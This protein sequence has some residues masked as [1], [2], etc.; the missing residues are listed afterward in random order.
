MIIMKQFAKFPI[1]FLATSLILGC[2]IPTIYLGVPYNFDGHYRSQSPV[3]DNDNF[4]YMRVANGG[5]TVYFGGDNLDNIQGLDYISI[6]AVNIE[7]FEENSYSFETENL[8]GKITF[9]ENTDVN[10]SLSKNIV[11]TFHIENSVL[12]KINSF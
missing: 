7:S 11:P 9:K 6:R 3:L 10:I 5:L 8:R 4:L 1:L 2:A 12:N